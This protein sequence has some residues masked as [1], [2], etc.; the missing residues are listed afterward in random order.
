MSKW[1]PLRPEGNYER[2]IRPKEERDSRKEHKAEK[3]RDRATDRQI[4][5]DQRKKEGR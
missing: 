5:A 1:H 4:E 2:P 3:A